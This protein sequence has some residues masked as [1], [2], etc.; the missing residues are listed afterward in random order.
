M[1]LFVVVEETI[2][3]LRK[4]MPTSFLASGYEAYLSHNQSCQARLATMRPDTTLLKNT[5]FQDT[6]HHI[7]IIMHSIGRL[8]AQ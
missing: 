1:I 7:G 5:V 4:L 3:R 8:F 2:K 6:L